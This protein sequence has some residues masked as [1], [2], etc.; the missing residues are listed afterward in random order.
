MMTE[1]RSVSPVTLTVEDRWFAGLDNRLIQVG[2]QRR[3]IR[4]LGIHRDGR[5]VWIQLTTLDEGRG[6]VI[7]CGYQQR[8]AEVLA[9]LCDHLA[10]SPSAP[11]VIDA[12][13]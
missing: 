9:K 8:T 1:A 3:L 13:L 4:I 7:R 6:F 11:R 10:S 5:D 2:T 12:R